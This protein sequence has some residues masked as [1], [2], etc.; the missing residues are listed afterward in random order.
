MKIE[1]MLNEQIDFTANEKVISKYILSHK[2]DVLHM[3]IS[4]PWT[5]SFGSR[6]IPYLTQSRTIPQKAY[7]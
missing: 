1:T 2:E 6:F 7:W 3:T 4:M 5:I